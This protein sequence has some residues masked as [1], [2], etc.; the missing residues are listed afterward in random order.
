MIII[1]GKKI[2][3]DLRLNLKTEVDNLKKKFDKVPCLTV[4]L[5]GEY[6]PSKIYV[7]NKEKSAEEIGLKSEIVKYPET[8]DEK[9]VLKKIYKIENSISE[10]LSN[11]ILDL[12][13]IFHKKFSNYRENFLLNKDLY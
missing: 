11:Q 12:S 8:V 5:I 1:D 2:A 10:V 13:L 7:R 6:A 9:T 4:I 3:A